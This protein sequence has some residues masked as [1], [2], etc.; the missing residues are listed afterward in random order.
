MFERSQV[1]SDSPCVAIALV[2]KDLVFNTAS[3]S[4]IYLLMFTQITGWP[5]RLLNGLMSGYLVLC[6]NKSTS[7]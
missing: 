2:I 4:M 7:P 5:C 1:V 3:E 6:M